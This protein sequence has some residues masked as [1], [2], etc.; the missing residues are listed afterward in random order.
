MRRSLYDHFMSTNVFNI[1]TKVKQQQK[2]MGK[3]K[4]LFRQM[5]EQELND[6][7]INEHFFFCTLRDEDS[8]DSKINK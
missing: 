3:V 4:E 2:R 6:H 5:R 8:D 7:F 1:A